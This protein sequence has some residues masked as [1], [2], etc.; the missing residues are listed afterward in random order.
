MMQRVSAFAVVAA[1]LGAVAAGV[2]GAKAQEAIQI[3]I[4]TVAPEAEPT[5]AA[6]RSFGAAV[7][8]AL[9]GKVQVRVFPGGSL[10]RQGTE[11]TAIQRGQLEMATPL[12]FEIEQQIP[13]YGVLGAPFTFRDSDHLMKV[14]RGAIGKEYYAEVEKRMQLMALDIGYIGT[15]HVNLR[16]HKDVKT[17]ADWSGM[18]L[19]VQPG[20]RTAISIG[21]GLGLTPVPMP[22]TEVYLSLK[23]GTI[24]ATDS[25]IPVTRATKVEEIIKQVTL[26]GHL[27]QP[28]VLVIGKHVWDKLAPDQQAVLRKEA[29]AAMEGL[30]KHTAD[31]EKSLVKEFEAKGIRFVTPDREA[32]RAAMMKQLEQDGLTAR[33]K[34]GLADAIAAVK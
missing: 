7:E 13:E 30:Y 31:E 33:W 16:E 27:V 21:R 8:K 1:L 22:V 34:P 20:G 2:P 9:P 10:F 28:F 29:A 4:S 24:D 5:V 12:F 32:F 14:M 6:L 18:K 15:R 26:T 25:P 11:I 3:R 17:P 19:R 23:T